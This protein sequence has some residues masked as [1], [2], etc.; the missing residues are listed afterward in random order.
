MRPNKKLTRMIRN[1]LHINKDVLELSVP[2]VEEVTNK[3]T[4]L[5]PLKHDF[6]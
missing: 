1:I 2:K 3:P 6:A 4:K 5:T